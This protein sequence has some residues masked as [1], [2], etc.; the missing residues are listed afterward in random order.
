V[1]KILVI[2]DEEPVRSVIIAFLNIAEFQVLEAAD[3]LAGIEIAKQHIPDLIICDVNMPKMD[4]YGVIT[5]LR[6][7]PLTATIPFIFLTGKS[8]R[9][10]LRVGMNLGADDYLT[11]PFRRAELLEA[12]EARFAKQAAVT[13]GYSKKLKEAEEKLNFLMHHD[14]ITGLPNRLMLGEKLNEAVGRVNDGQSIAILSIGLDRFKRINE[15]LGNAAGD[16]LLRLVGERLKSLTS[17]QETLARLNADQFAII[18]GNVNQKEDVASY[19]QNILNRLAD[20]FMI[21]DQEVYATASIGITIYPADGTDIDQLIKHAEAAMQHAKKQGGNGWKYYVPEIT[22][23]SPDQLALEASLRHAL[24]RNEFEMYYQ[25]QVDFKTGTIVGAEGLI[26]WN[27]PERGRISPAIFIPIAE[28]CGF[29]IPIGEW[30]LRTAFTQAKKWQDAGFPAL[31]MSVNLS[32]AQFDQ[33]DLPEKLERIVQETDVNASCLDIELTESIIVRNT[34]SAI[35]TINRIKALGLQISIDDFGTGY[36]SL[37]YLKQFQ[38]DI[39]K[40]DQ[41]F[42]RNVTVDS[43]NTAITMAIIQMARNLGLKVIAEGVETTGELF[44]L[45]LHECNEFQGYLFSPPIPSRDFE[46]LLTTGKRLQIEI[47][48]N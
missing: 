42:I 8:E 2:E 20:M 33:A 35:N 5:T 19:A 4:G 29:I 41:S 28:E 25:P 26:R 30:A 36:S 15:T 12:I 37:N 18:L 23:L 11:K 16:Q 40:V 6:N 45:A 27:H 44:F 7:D 13:E 46:Q 1:K 39:L 43:K 47:S 14:T 21:G 24:A 34:Q 9:Q 17:E 38:F 3:G 32:A 31:R 48:K 10:D 22:V